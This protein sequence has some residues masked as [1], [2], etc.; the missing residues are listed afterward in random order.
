[1][2]TPRAILLL[3]ATIDSSRAGERRLQGPPL[4]ISGTAPLNEDSDEIAT[5]SA[6][7]AGVA[8]CR[9]RR[10]K[11]ELLPEREVGERGGWWGSGYPRAP[12]GA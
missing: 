7:S 4:C 9:L 11:G 2:H 12:L 3:P 8:W 10:E 6:S 1:L 5:A